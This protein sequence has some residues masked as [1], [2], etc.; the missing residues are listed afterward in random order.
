MKKKQKLRRPRAFSRRD[1]CRFATRVALLLALGLFAC[2]FK[3]VSSQQVNA[4]FHNA[5]LREVFRSL[6]QQTGVFFVFSERE[7]DRTSRVSAKLND[8]DLDQ[9]LEEVLRNLPYTHEHVNGMIVIRPAPG[10]RS[11]QA[12]PLKRVAG[13]VKDVAGQPMAGVSIQL[14]NTRS[15]TV[16]DSKGNFAISVLSSE[17]VLV[18]SF[19]G[20]KTREVVVGEETEIHV[21]L[22]DQ[23]ENI[24]EVVV[25]GIFR[26]T[27]ESFTG[28][29][30]TFTTRELKSVGNQNVLQSLKTLDPSF[31]IIENNEFGSDPNRLPDIEVRGKSS[32]IGLTEQYGTDPNQPLFILDGFETT[33][34]TISDL[35]MDRVESITV[36]KDAAATAIYGSKAANGVIVVETL[37]PAIGQLKLSYNLNLSFGFADLTD[38][39][40]MNALEKVTFERLAS[41]YGSTDAEGNIIS[42][43]ADQPYL[44]RLKEV[45]RGVETYWM[46]EPLRFAVTH[47]HTLFL[48]GGDAS[49]RYGINLSHGNTQGVMK[50]SNRNVISGGIRL[51]Y[52]KGKLSFNNSLDLDYVL[53]ERESVPFSAFSRANPYH[54][55]Y[56]ENGGVDMILDSY[57]FIDLTVPGYYRYITNYNP[58]HD[59][60]NNNL[61][62]SE[63][64]GF[65]N[66]L[67]I[68]W[69]A[70]EE[71]RGR[72]RLGITK[73]TENSRRFRSPFN[74]EFA[75][76]D[77]L[78][79]GL[80]SESDT[81]Q[82]NYDGEISLTY[83][84]LL[85]E[86]HIINVVTGLR[87]DQNALRAGGYEVQGFVDDDFSNPA[88]AFGYTAGKKPGYQESKRR[89]ASY[90]LN[91]GYAY[92]RRY[93]L[94][95]N[96][97]SDGSSVYGTSKQIT[98]TWSI[99]L[100]WNL[101]NE[102][103]FENTGGVSL[104]K[105]R[106]SVGNPG[107]QNF[108]DYISTR[109]YSY[110]YE[111]SNPFG[112]SVIINTPGNRNLEWQKTL[113]RNI[114]VD[115]IVLQERL[116]V[117]VDY[118]NKKTD[119][120]LVFIGMPSS[121]GATSV[122]QNLGEQVTK[123]ITLNANCTILR[124]NDL[125]WAV[126]MN[127]RHL[128][129]EYREINQ[130]LD[131][132]NQENKSRNLTRY[133]DGASPTDL[134]AVRS[135]GI[136]PAT[137]R[138]VFLNK[139]GNQTF[140]H[141]YDNETVV[142]NS[143]PKVD[144]VIGSSFHYRGITMAVNLR[145]RLGGQVF[146]HTLYEK[147][148]NIS[149]SNVLLNQDKRALYDRWKNPGDNAKFKSISMSDTT[150]IS[151]RFVEDNNILAGESISISYET[152]T[153]RWLK[154]IGASSM[155]F[156]GYMNDI[157]RISTVKNERGIDYPFARS[158][159]MSLGIR[160]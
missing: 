18:F 29:S 32:V 48:E 41:Y 135:A 30:T 81:R 75:E 142:G 97:R 146:M 149:K 113:D 110:N 33:L 17:D 44:E 74:S 69:H 19:I 79:K 45:K 83:G 101:H 138:E 3:P 152:T 100:G 58:L 36:L 139:N 27:R 131:K 76:S 155:T 108:N 71:L 114:G 132:Y 118:F 123:G 98:A 65:T 157:F 2:S 49:M 7:I 60:R 125:N 10:K 143:E 20:M 85:G 46:N 57:S 50:E 43:T 26:R 16:T 34:R 147:V 13:T 5:T 64:F 129:S 112:S 151:S 53:A 105:L 11:P 133:Y 126:N 124:R 87:F 150:P 22:E 130:S 35:S 67:E 12:Q 127:T 25:T 52:R 15:G 66:R 122:P 134:W 9:A 117:N 4:E 106:A 56:N 62:E 73:S 95:V 96:F 156:R 39:N 158:V 14:K 153:A 68:E 94:D 99:G 92:N 141:D 119:P 121:I 86:E 37:R 145:Y 6:R 8:L 115:L 40:L 82:M 63:L 136:D 91:T 93:L 70:L 120:L 42:E 47:K 78:Q 159:S 160:F 148:E 144:G 109:I 72:F 24:S 90:Y 107:N 103:F 102:R 31:A 88:F 154:T 59:M 89:S 128:K 140:L 104:L 55:K 111:I 21:V 80:Y 77:L 28:S 1:A 137:G 54:R 116:R 61:Y 38:Y 84:S 23:P 51:L